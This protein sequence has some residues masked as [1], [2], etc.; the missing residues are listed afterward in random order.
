MLRALTDEDLMLAAGRGDRRAFEQLAARHHDGL[1][2]LFL[3]RGLD[4]HAAED[5]VQ[6]TMLRLLRAAGS[7]RPRAPF[8]A[9]LLRL[10][11]N[12]FVDWRRR[13]AAEPALGAGAAA[14]DELRAVHRGLHAG[15]RL[16]LMQAVDGLSS[17]L[18]AVVELS[19]RGGY[20]Q[21]EIARL[22][23]LPHGTVK[24]RMHW[25]VRKLRAALSEG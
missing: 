9:F 16:D 5:C 25:A 10:A 11:R 7:Y 1:R 12:A 4:G 20:S 15:D 22:L 13:R 6:D 17:K 21:P 23:G 24:T 3:R 19:V 2:A 14:P 8:R 18:R